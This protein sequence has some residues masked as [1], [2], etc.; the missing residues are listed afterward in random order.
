MLSQG[1][2]SD[3]VL[4]R[5]IL[6][7]FLGLS[8]QGTYLMLVTYQFHRELAAI[9]ELQSEN[10]RRSQALDLRLSRVELQQARRLME[11]A[12]HV[13]LRTGQRPSAAR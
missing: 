3:R 6:A 12:P 11:E 10:L 1:S 13:D 2:S 8:V 5:S 4:R 7:L 9:Q